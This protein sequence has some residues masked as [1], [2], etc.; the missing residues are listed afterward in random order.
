MQISIQ[1]WG[2]SLGI[3]IPSYL[4]KRLSLH[5]GSMVEIIMQDNNIV[6][7]PKKYNLADFLGKIT[8]SNQHDESWNENS[9]GLEEW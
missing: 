3:R 1:K 2:N 8:N 9:Q 5:D 4:L 7:S 6:L